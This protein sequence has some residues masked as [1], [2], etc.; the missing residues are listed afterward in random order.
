MTKEYEDIKKYILENSW[1][2]DK[3]EEIYPETEI[4][5]LKINEDEQ[6]IFI[7]GYLF[8]VKFHDNIGK[9]EFDGDR[10][11]TLENEKFIK[12]QGNDV[13]LAIDFIENEAYECEVA[14]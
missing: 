8:P 12:I 14:K 6:L 1:D 9:Y 2:I 3:F 7:D 5:C 4:P 13:L 10:F 11:Y